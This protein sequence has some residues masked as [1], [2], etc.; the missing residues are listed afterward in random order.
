MYDIAPEKVNRKRSSDFA[1]QQEISREPAAGFRLPAPS[2]KSGGEGATSGDRQ[3]L[4]S[5]TTLAGS[6]QLEAGGGSA[7]PAAASGQRRSCGS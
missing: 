3:R 4:S 5:D 7:K 2:P 1:G 6:R